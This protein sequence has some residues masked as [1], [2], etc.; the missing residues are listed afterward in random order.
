MP[1][2][3]K[4]G[5]QEYP[6]FSEQEDLRVTIDNLPPEERV[7][8]LA[9]TFARIPVSGWK[10]SVTQRQ[11]TIAMRIGVA[12]GIVLLIVLVMPDS[13]R[14]LSRMTGQVIHTIVPPPS[15]TL[16]PDYGRFYLDA[17]IPGTTVMLDEHPISLPRIGIDAPLHLSA[18]RHTLFWSVPPFNAQVCTISI[19]FVA[20]DT[21][22]FT[23]TQVFYHNTSYQ[24][25]LLPESLS[26]LT[27]KQRIQLMSTI[28]RALAALSTTETVEKG[29][30]FTGSNGPTVATQTMQ[31]TL[32]MHFHLQQDD[33]TCQAFVVMLAQNGIPCKI[34]GQSCA[35]LCTIPWQA[36][37]H[38]ATLLG[39]STWLAFATTDASWTYHTPDGQLVGSNEPLGAGGSLLNRQ[40]VFLRI[41]WKIMWNVQVLLG[42]ELQSP[43]YADWYAERGLPHTPSTSL[44]AMLVG[45]D[46]AC[47]AAR[48]YLAGGLARAPINGPV[49]REEHVYLVSSSNLAQGCLIE[50]TSGGTNQNGVTGHVIG[51]TA[52]YIV[53]FG[54]LEAANDV[55]YLQAPELPRADAHALQIVDMLKNYPGQDV[56]LQVG[57]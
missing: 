40:M 15:P 10:P 48:G 41:T 39:P 20:S 11:F 43:I 27:S 9:E 19:P 54:V 30:L 25:I 42:S 8:S 24:V 50:V 26:D 29:E 37:Q 55:A 45:D 53:R 38:Y 34:E 56:T 28:E 3:P 23:I 12:I 35:Q 18:G 36:R 47:G 49:S 4:Q 57:G 52:Y 44:E 5:S 22:H 7:P 1:E 13:A 6:R 51:D 16:P 32:T 2:K 31:A 46:P 21:C 14:F 17:A 33:Q